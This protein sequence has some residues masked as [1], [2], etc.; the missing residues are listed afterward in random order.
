M[1]TGVSFYLN[2]IQ[3][4]YPPTLLF[5]FILNTNFELHNKLF[6]YKIWS[7]EYSMRTLPSL[8][9]LRLAFENVG[10]SIG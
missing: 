3:I 6:V 7:I 5:Y 10:P 4:T 8:P 2:L 9:F 1:A